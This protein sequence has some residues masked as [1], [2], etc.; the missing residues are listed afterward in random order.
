MDLLCLFSG[1]SFLTVGSILGFRLFGHKSV[2]ASLALTV[3][4]VHREAFGKRKFV[5]EVKFRG[6]KS[7]A[8]N[9][10]QI[11]ALSD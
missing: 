2:S 8:A 9:W 6:E 10:L 5:D 7:R 11:H 3:L 4:T 1:F